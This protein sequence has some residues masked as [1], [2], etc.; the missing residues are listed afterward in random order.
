M[1]HCVSLVTKSIVD[2]HQGRV[3][4]ASEGEGR[5]CTFTVDLPCTARK[6]SEAMDSS[7]NEMD[8]FMPISPRC[9]VSPSRDTA[10][11]GAGGGVGGIGKVMSMHS[12]DFPYP[13]HGERNVDEHVDVQQEAPIDSVHRVLVVD[14]APINRKM[15][16]RSLMD[17]YEHIEESADGAD[18]LSKVRD[19]LV[20]E[21]NDVQ[22]HIILMD[23]QMPHMDG[24]TAAKEMRA[25][26]YKGLIIGVTGNTS[27]ADLDVFVRNGA[28][29][30]MSKPISVAG[31]ET[32]IRGEYSV[33][34]YTTPPS[35]PFKL[36][37]ID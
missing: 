4:V 28:D 25:L 1:L 19:S 30:V 20:N 34:I 15:L 37:S 2:L 3:F 33:R 9:P 35:F 27:H 24:P 31:L 26:G 12:D 36:F 23:Q 10:W 8:T 5:G 22:Y 17:K 11:A 29:V 16:I 21:H 32:C 6:D 18:A 7:V 14:D 13:F